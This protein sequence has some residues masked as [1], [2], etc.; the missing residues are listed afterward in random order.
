M[1]K[2]TL[3]IVSVYVITYNS[4]KT[5]Q[6]TLDSID[7]QSYPQIE[8]IISD[9]CS[10][11]DTVT[12]CNRW[13]D[14]HM[15]RFLRTDVITVERNTGLAS[16]INRA[17][18]AC[19][20][21]WVKGI[22]GDDL[23]TPNCIKDCM[24]YISEHPDTIYLFGRC[25]AFGAATDVCKQI[26]DR[27]NYSFF[28]LPIDEQL[29]RLL[30]EGNCLPATTVFY[31]RE[32]AKEIG[33]T[34]DER[35]PYLDDWPKW[36]NLLKAGVRFEFVDKTI[37]KY[38]V[39]EAALSTIAKPSSKFLRSNAVFYKL[40]RFRYEYE[41]V[42]KKQAIENWLR[43]QSTITQNRFWYILFKIYKVCIMRKLH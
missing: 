11:D 35:I 15:S 33:V 2:Y 5:I 28:S 43:A 3:P 21:E 22:A 1:D 40:Y 16:N 30:T 9:D 12:I 37:I 17:E 18:A 29:H 36:I 39:S 7:A 19:Q 23:M 20:G 13:I 6:E 32:R 24:D 8:L 42:S 25:K 41:H 34:N 38:R 14:C 31:H 27:F 10:T 26:D 4:S